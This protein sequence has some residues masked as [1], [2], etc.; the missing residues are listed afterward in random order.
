MSEYI[1]A[2]RKLSASC[3]FGNLQD[4]LIKDKIV[5]GVR[6]SRLK[7]RLLKEDNLTLDTCVKICQ[8]VELAENRLKSMENE[9]K[10]DAIKT[11]KNKNNKHGNLN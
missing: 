11:D 2:L 4:R 8:A 6:D 10:V 7:E 3:G 5:C 1:L 9:N